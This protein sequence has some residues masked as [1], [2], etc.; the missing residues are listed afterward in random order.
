MRTNMPHGKFA[1]HQGYTC[2]SVWVCVC[3]CVCVGG[4]GGIDKTMELFFIFHFCFDTLRPR[5]SSRHFPYHIFKS[6]FLNENIWVLLK[7]S[8]MLV[9]KVRIND[10]PTLVQIRAWRRS[11]DKS[12]AEQMIVS[13]QMHICV[14]RPRWDKQVL[15]PWSVTHKTHDMNILYIGSFMVSSPVIIP[16]QWG[17]MYRI[18]DGIIFSTNFLL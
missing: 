9:P 16:H 15:V 2:T 7:I 18:N 14:T 6:I 12:L 3:V 8:L 10:I 11:G 5:R 1:V 13:L 17:N 4:G